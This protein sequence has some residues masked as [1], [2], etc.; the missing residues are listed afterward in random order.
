MLMHAIILQN[1]AVDR[2]FRAKR[3]SRSKKG[4]WSASHQV[5]DSV[6]GDV[7]PGKSHQI[8]IP[9]ELKL[10]EDL[11][12]SQAAGQGEKAVE[13]SLSVPP[14]TAEGA[15]KEGAALKKGSQPRTLK[16]KSPRT[17]PVKSESSIVNVIVI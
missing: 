4:R 15:G 16:T 11:P 3:K 13:P 9:K 1:E 8:E 14:P 17:L 10:I 2:A 5:Q 12:S 7:V 6:D